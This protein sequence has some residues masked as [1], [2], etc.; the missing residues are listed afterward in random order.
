LPDIENIQNENFE[1]TNQIRELKKTN[2]RF[3]KKRYSCR[4]ISE[5]RITKKHARK[6]RIEN[7]E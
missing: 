1:L 3:I 5:F 7:A 4:K 2:I 6:H